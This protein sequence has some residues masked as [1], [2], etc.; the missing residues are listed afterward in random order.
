MVGVLTT[1]KLAKPINEAF[2]FLFPK[3]WLFNIYQPIT[4]MDVPTIEIHRYKHT[5]SSR[6]TAKI[7]LKHQ[8]GKFLKE[9]IVSFST[10]FFRRIFRNPL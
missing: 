5:S 3:S 2:L 4:G 8:R 1:Q 6:T 7:G 10:D 9:Y